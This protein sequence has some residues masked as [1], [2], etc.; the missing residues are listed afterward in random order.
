MYVCM[1]SSS[2]RYRSALAHMC[3]HAYYSSGYSRYIHKALTAPLWAKRVINELTAMLG[4]VVIRYRYALWSR[5][6][7]SDC[8]F[9]VAVS[10]AFPPSPFLSLINL[11]V[12]PVLQH[13]YRLLYC[14]VRSYRT[15]RKENTIHA[16]QPH[17]PVG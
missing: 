13:G 2:H 10:F 14:K 16:G 8:L 7:I 6:L 3:V 11:R 5:P 1:H 12:I 4:Y 17:I 15:V 9:S